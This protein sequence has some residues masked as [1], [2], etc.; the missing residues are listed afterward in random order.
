MLSKLLENIFLKRLQLIINAKDIIP[1]H[2][3]GFSANHS[4]ADQ[5]LR[6]TNLIEDAFEKGKVC[7]AVFL[8]VSQAFDNSFDATIGIL[9]RLLLLIPKSSLL[10]G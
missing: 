6:I 8:D 2:Q 7:F 5:V 3:F 4:T 1:F 9:L 10:Q